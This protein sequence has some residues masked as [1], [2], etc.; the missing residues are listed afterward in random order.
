MQILFWWLL[1]VGA[2]AA[3]IPDP[4]M[5]AAS[6]F[7]VEELARRGMKHEIQLAG[8]NSLAAEE[9][10][11]QVGAKITIAASGTRGWMYGFG[12]YLMTQP[13]PGST[14]RL[15]PRYALRGHQLGYRATAN[16]YDAWSIAQYEEYIRELMLSGANAVENIP[17][18][19]DKP[20][21]LMKHTREEMNLA[22]SALCA[23]YDL[24]YWLWVPADFDLSDQARRQAYLEKVHAM[25]KSLP[26]FDGFFF[27]GGDPG[28]NPPEPVLQLLEEVGAILRETHPR[29]K[30]RLSLQGFDRAK[31]DRVYSYIQAQRPK[32]LGGLV[33]G[34]SSP[35]LARTRATLPAEYGLRLYPDI[36]HNKLSQ[37][38]VEEWDQ[39]FALTLGREAI[40]PRPGQYKRIFA[41]IAPW[42]NGFISYSDGAHDDVNKFVFNRLAWQPELD[43]RELALQYARLFFP[44]ANAGTAADQILALERNWRGPLLSNGAVEAVLASWRSLGDSW[45]AQ[46]LDFRAVYDAYIRRK[47]IEDRSREQQA[48]DALRAGNSQRA[49]E[50]LAQ[51]SGDAALRQRI[52]DLGEALYRSI[53]LQS[54]VALYGASGAERGAV[55]DFLDLPLNNRYWLEDEIAKA[56]NLEP[57]QRMQRYRELAAWEDPGPGGYYDDLGHIERSPRV[58]G[59]FS[60]TYW[61]LDQGR[62]RMRLSQQLTMWPERITYEALEPAARYVLRT[63]GYGKHLPSANGVRLQ[64]TSSGERNEFVIPAELYRERKLEITF[65]IPGDEGHLNW[66]QHSR[67]AEVWLVKQ[68]D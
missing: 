22:L 30:V 35:P 65:T 46:M 24:E 68:P 54:S 25:L 28:H 56:Q 27:P 8:D 15:K 40:N 52:L 62:S 48:N 19:D 42:S 32:W 64:Q 53:G 5:T 26:R 14:V 20:A 60:P 29:A 58:S 9:F 44:R 57:S 17:F 55:L 10:R 4:K 37:F 13:P 63:S 3:Q 36:T 33:A 49:L 51:P 43:A 18:Q 59:R 41:A 21:P 66:R 11:L 47:L 50:L 12:H 31:E 45:R 23:K 61:W 7:I 38:E 2:V 6:E 39:A 34:P 67:L 1:W 16:S